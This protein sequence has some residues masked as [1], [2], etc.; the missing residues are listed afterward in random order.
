TLSEGSSNV[1]GNGS[2]YTNTHGTRTLNL[3]KKLNDKGY[4]VYSVG[5]EMG[6]ENGITKAEAEQLVINMATSP[7][8]AFLASNVQE[9]QSHLESI[10]A[11]L[12]NTI[13]NG[14]VT[15]PITDE[16]ILQENP[17]T[18]A[19][20]QDLSNGEYYLSASNQSLLEGVEV[21]A[22]G[23][24]IY[25]DGLNLG[26]GEEVT[27]RYKV[28]I[29]TENPDLDPNELYKTNGTTTLTP[30]GDDPDNKHKFPE[31][32]AS[33]VPIEVSGQKI[34]IDYGIEE[35]R[36][37]SITVQLIREIKGED[38]VVVEKEI[39]TDG[40]NVWDYQFDD[41]FLYDT[42]GEKI[43]YKIKEIVPEE[44]ADQYESESGEF[45]DGTINL[46][47]VLKSNPDIQLVKTGVSTS[48]HGE[49]VI[50]VEQD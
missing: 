42:N 15:D 39:S 21:R 47:N 8:H 26:A 24:H 11:A 1:E 30:N 12:D 27:V 10:A 23:Q 7:D 38:V 29:D 50:E 14:S 36:P 16:F 5:I 34:W 28:Q 17:F 35:Y 18:Q 20:D 13:R 4:T 9:V 43:E 31:P 22:E 3:L 48:E 44:V 2:T 32:E 46:R 33:T 19:T 6:A 37:D 41:V 49:D 45:S 25:V 40:T